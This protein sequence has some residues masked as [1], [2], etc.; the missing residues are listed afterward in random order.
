MLIE[1]V[2]LSLIKSGAFV[3]AFSIVNAVSAE[4]YQIPDSGVEVFFSPKG[5]CTEAIVRQLSTARTNVLVQAYSFT[6]TPISKALA[7]AQRRGVKVDVIL[8]RS[9]RTQKYSVADFFVQAGIAT[10][11]D[12]KHAIAHNKVIVVDG[13]T[14]L[15]G[16]FNFTKAAEENNAENLLVIHDS[17]LAASYAQNWKE[18]RRHAVPY[19]GR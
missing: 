2:R 16:S 1:F 12:E 6:S 10:F 13:H 19:L 5:G 15:T 8:D 4:K 3:V 17:S 14:V 18:H 11:L 7:D 9:Q